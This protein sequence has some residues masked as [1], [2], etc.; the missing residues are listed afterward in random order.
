MLTRALGCTQ[1]ARLSTNIESCMWANS[2]TGKFGS[3]MTSMM[4]RSDSVAVRQG[5]GLTQAR[6]WLEWGSSTAET[7]DRNTG[8]R[9]DLPAQIFCK[10]SPALDPQNVHLI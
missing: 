10:I 3:V 1:T 2:K 6:F 8:T 4:T 7:W 5:T 9:C